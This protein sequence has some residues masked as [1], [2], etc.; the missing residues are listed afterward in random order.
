MP[1]EVISNYHDRQFLY[2]DE[3]PRSV[4]ED[5]LDW[6]TEDD[7]DGYIRYRDDW[8]HL[9]QFMRCDGQDGWHSC[10]GDSYFSGVFIAISDDGETY[11]IASYYQ[12]G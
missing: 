4:L 12:K 10:H 1:L 8:Y 3:V 5:E 6:T 2:R 9:R 7:M 11:R